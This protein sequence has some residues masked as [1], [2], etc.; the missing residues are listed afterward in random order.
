MINHRFAAEGFNY[1]EVPL[2][3]PAERNF[4][5]VANNLYCIRLLRKQSSLMMNVP[6]SAPTDSVIKDLSKQ[7]QL[8]DFSL[9]E[10]QLCRHDSTPKINR[11]IVDLNYF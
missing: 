8:D 10:V 1:Q 2:K 11:K 4:R 7:F 5:S 6:A 3:D 9:T